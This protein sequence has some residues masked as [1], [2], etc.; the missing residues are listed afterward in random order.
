[1]TIPLRVAEFEGEID[2]LFNGYTLSSSLVDSEE[3]SDENSSDEGHDE[4]GGV[5]DNEKI[6]TNSTSPKADPFL[7][8]IGENIFSENFADFHSE[9]GSTANMGFRTKDKSYLH[10]SANKHE[11]APHNECETQ[12]KST[13]PCSS[14]K[15][16][17]NL[18]STPSN[19]HVG[20]NDTSPTISL[21]PNQAQNNTKKS[22]MSNT[23]TISE[24]RKLRACSSLP[25]TSS[26]LMQ[27]SMRKKK[28]SHH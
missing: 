26:N 21:N 24:P 6:D 28:D 7:A 8:N 9:E 3:E 13:I 10:S 4:E 12:D 1:E 16:L 22:K 23:K 11:K 20:C 19:S 18:H 2:S 15:L 17:G 14:H 25:S 27:R 5:G